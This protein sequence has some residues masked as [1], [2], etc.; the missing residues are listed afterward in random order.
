M[1]H[2]MRSMSQREKA[3]LSIKNYSCFTFVKPPI[4]SECWQHLWVHAWTIL[5]ANVMKTWLF[6]SYVL[7]FFCHSALIFFHNHS[8]SLILFCIKSKWYKSRLEFILPSIQ[9]V[10]QHIFCYQCCVINS[11]LS[12]S[13]GAG[14]R[15]AME[16]TIVELVVWQQF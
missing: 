8:S 3:F 2:K 14:W 12:K 7:P 13:F 16:K 5:R 4:L 9:I 6:I 1:S 11:I 10:N 15:S